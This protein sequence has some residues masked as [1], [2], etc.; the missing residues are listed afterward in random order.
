MLGWLLISLLGCCIPFR[1][2]LRR[3]SVENN[4]EQHCQANRRDYL[5]DGP[6]Y[7]VEVF[8]RQ[9]SEDDRG[10]SPRSEPANEDT[11]GQSNRAAS[12]EIATEN[13]DHG[14]TQHA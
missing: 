10:E 4:A 7:A 9:Q 14:Q 5:A 13:A 1:Q 11:V 2:R 3:Q 8:Q 12:S 6:R